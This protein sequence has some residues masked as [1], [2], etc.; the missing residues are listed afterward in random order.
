M[1]KTKHGGLAE[2]CR[3]GIAPGTRFRSG[4]EESD[5]DVMAPRA[6]KGL[7][8]NAQRRFIRESGFSSSHIKRVWDL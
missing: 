5:T 6:I 8:N 2:I 3:T 7:D 1:S 4:A